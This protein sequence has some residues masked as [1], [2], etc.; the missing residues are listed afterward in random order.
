MLEEQP[1]TSKTVSHYR[2]L[3][4][5]G[6]GGMGVVYKA[7]DSRLDRFV[8]LKFLPDDL[9]RNPQALERF[10]REAKAASA[11]NHP[12]IC[13][14]YDIGEE[15]NR[16][17]IAM[18][19]LEGRTLKHA[20]AS[21]SLKL[22]SLLD[23]AIE[24]AD[25]LDAA[26]AK[27]I[28]HRDIKPA[29][30]F[31][32]AHGH[33]KVL[34]FGLAKMPVAR[35][36]ADRAT[37]LATH[38][39]DPDHLTSPGSTL[40]T[41]AYMS[42]EQVRA[43]ALDPRTDIFS[44]GVV[45]YEAATG[46]LPFR[47]QSS[48]VILSAILGH[49]QIPPI[50]VNPEIPP[51]LDRI[52]NKTLEKDRNLRYQSASEL[53]ADLKRLRRDSESAS[54]LAIPAAAAARQRSFIP[55]ALA[56]VALLALIA[57]VAVYKW[58]RSATP[59]PGSNWEQLTF[60]TDSAV[61]PS[62]SP[63][64]RM[65]TFIRGDN[66]FLGTGQV[67]VKLLPSGEPVQL[68][69]DDLL[70]MSPGFSPDGSRIVYSTVAPWE[71]WE[72]PVLGGDPRMTLPNS[73]SL[74]WIQDGSRLLFSEFDKGLHLIVVTTDQARGQKRV[75]YAP[76][77]E[78]GM[79]HHSYLSPDGQWML[80]TEMDARGQFEP[81]KVVPF[82]RS[83][84]PQIV[85]PPADSCA[86]GAWSVDG[87]Y[88]YVTS[89]HGGKTHIWRQRFPGGQ[90]E[91]VTSGTTEEAG[92][93]MAPDGK[94]FITSV[95]TRDTA[96]WLH[97]KSGD[98]QIVSEGDSLGG[99][100]SPDGKRLYYLYATDRTKGHEVWVLNLADGKTERVLPG[101]QAEAYTVSADGKRIVI[102]RE[103]ER[104]H[105]SLWI[106]P[107]DHS[108]APKELSSA[109]SED[110]PHF[111]PD[112]NL[113]FR[114]SEGGV[115]TLSRMHSDGTARREIGPAHTLDFDGVSP[116]G[117]WAIVLTY[118]LGTEE[119]AG[120][121]AVPVD[122]GSSVE[123]CRT[124][125]L[126]AWT[127]HGESML[128]RDVGH[129]QEGTYVVPVQPGIGVPKLPPTGIADLEDLKAIRDVKY[130]PLFIDSSESSD[131]YAFTRVTIHRNLYRIPV[132]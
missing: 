6:E 117:R 17:F 129:V 14:I 97:D 88:V 121:F 106:A 83:G 16:V 94:S 31:V 73:S 23:T 2:I 74:T 68:T 19:F 56:S 120:E 18:E 37:T 131:L 26:H 51:E 102:A 70:K 107:T 105:S 10:R 36:A 100:L 110:S 104:G 41:A 101:Y 126:L 1:L 13:T 32:T 99:T 72:V 47:G 38:D 28:I 21:G 49:V 89:A 87:K 50:R 48:G 103:D 90:P 55:I 69:H 43:E 45:L 128:F 52:I 124:I 40:G 75:V 109:A 93:T 33:A 59:A 27:G 115:N 3:E 77:S 58:P 116:D 61:Y 20:M 42:P 112:G 85:G 66:A 71:T 127:V 44:F 5:L 12:N 78:R 95:G 113:L 57:V 39:L 92:I 4:K 98:R 108:S 76:P 82:E 91:Q 67:Y 132:Q 25:A 80:V 125:C 111:L 34:D 122:G 22:E 64:G 8:A 15:H 29:N 114:S 81:C 11:L 30:I 62:L 54:R 118:G 86:S 35:E 65:L 130:F 24:V 46:T 119:M 84:T 53:R 60:F 7:E 79:A 96:V 63:D 9:A 123:L